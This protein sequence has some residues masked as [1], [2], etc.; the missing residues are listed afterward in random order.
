[1]SSGIGSATTAEPQPRY[2]KSQRVGALR[3]VEIALPTRHDPMSGLRYTKSASRS[4]GIAPL[5]KQG[6]TNRRPSQARCRVRRRR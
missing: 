5:I 3:K 6:E 2:S 1:M 4:L